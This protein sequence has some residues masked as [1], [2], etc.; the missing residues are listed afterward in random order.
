MYQFI[1]TAS[2]SGRVK[3][4]DE[5]L[6]RFPLDDEKNIY[7]YIDFIMENNES[8]KYK[9][10][11]EIGEIVYVDKYTYNS[12]RKGY[13]HLFVVI[14]KEETEIS[15]Q[16]LAMLISSQ[17]KKIKYKQNVLLKKDKINNLKKNSIV[18]TDELYNINI[19]N[20]LFK[21]GNIEEKLILEYKNQFLVANEK[22]DY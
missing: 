7:Y 9:E 3:N 1:E 2:K 22:C 12:G 11:Y 21:I 18:K 19:K 13:D 5:A 16:Y 15:V 17:V 6:K 10:K 8:Y 14:D 20:I 4:L